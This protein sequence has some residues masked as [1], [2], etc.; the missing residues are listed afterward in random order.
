M[1]SCIVTVRY[2]CFRVTALGKLV[3]VAQVSRVSCQNRLQA[4]QEDSLY[5]LLDGLDE[6]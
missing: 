1:R 5:S 3:H 6:V 2:L 4:S